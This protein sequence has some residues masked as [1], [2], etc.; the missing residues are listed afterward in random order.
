MNSQ[1]SVTSEQVNSLP[2]LVGII[3][4]MG[5]RE[6]ID[7]EIKPHGH[8]QGASVGTI[9]TIWLSHMLMERDHRIVM[10]RDWAAERR[11]TINQLLNIQLRETDCSDDRL[12][13]ILS[14][15]GSGL[16]QA[17]LDSAYVQ[18]W[19][20]VY[21]LP[22]QLSRLDSTSVS[23]YHDSSDPDSIMQFGYSK[24]QRPD[25]KQF[26]VMMATLDPL[27]MPVMCQVVAGNEADETLYI[28][29]YDAAVAAMGSSDLLIVGDSKMAALAVRGHLVAGG[30]YYLCAYRPPSATKQINGW[31]DNALADSDH[32]QRIEEY[33]KQKGKA[34]LKAAVLVWER[35]QQYLDAGSEETYTWTERVLM[36]FSTAYQQALRTKREE[37]LRRLTEALEKFRQPPKRGRKRYRSAEDLHSAVTKL[38]DE[39]RLTGIVHYSLTQSSDGHWIVESVWLDLAAW[40]QMVAR[41]GWQVYVTNTTPQHYAA[42]ALVEAYNQ[43]PIHERGFARLK[44]RNLQIRPVYLRDEERIAGLLYLLCL[45]LRVLT[46]TEYRVR[47][48]LTQRNEKLVGLNPASRTQAT[49]KPTTERMFRIFSNITLTSF[50]DQSGHSQRHIT[51]LT[52]LQQQIILLLRLPPDLYHRLA[53]SNLTLHLRE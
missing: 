43:Q 24:D 37:T 13:N 40:Q 17:R 5:I 15:L 50:S 22:R 35:Q 44:T 7:A 39:H 9:V 14:M 26:K 12:A 51:P 29:A 53:A 25:L 19:V 33:N 47:Q 8:W 21:E 36:V 49:D 16:V 41:L 32:W 11:E 31:I 4:E 1:L 3:E 28:P 23:V 38:I 34:E 46:L 48:A 27:G 10:V 45:A 2:L 6:I 30:S 18:R 20:R 42:V 52:A